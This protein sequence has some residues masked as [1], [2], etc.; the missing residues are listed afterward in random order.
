[1]QN[2]NSLEVLSNSL[3]NRNMEGIYFGSTGVFFENK[4]EKV[5]L[6]VNRTCNFRCPYCYAETTNYKDEMS[7]DL[8][9]Q[10]ILFSKRMGAKAVILIGGE[11]L[12]YS[13]LDEIISYIND[14]EM[15][16]VV[17]TNGLEITKKRIQNLIND[18]KIYSIGFSLKG[19]D[20]KSY[21]EQT[22]VDSFERIK[23]AIS[24]FSNS[25]VQGTYSFVLTKQTHDKLEKVAQLVSYDNKRKLKFIL[26][27]PVVW[28]D[29]KISGEQMLPL[30][31][32]I[33]SFQKQYDEVNKVLDGRLV[34][35]QSLP[36]CVW[37]SD[38]IARL[39]SLNQIQFGC[40]I[41]SQKGLVFGIHGE[42]LICNSITDFPVAYF[43][44]DFCDRQSFISFINN[45]DK[46]DLFHKIL[47]YPLTQCGICDKKDACFGGCPFKWFV[48]S[49]QECRNVI[50]SKCE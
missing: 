36:T 15:K 25:S 18:N 31:E 24:I 1:M 5:W 43:G 7:L 12:L 49:A 34:L 41:R 4:L 23:E 32:L 46:K 19:W 17:V 47:K 13:K 39:K 44:R 38:F 16:V 35:Q 22:K 29:G 20:A 33:V 42:V 10:L 48:Y 30:S 3:L 9:K 11:P 28:G 45:E 27:N 2:L 21:L 26:C 50:Q 6:T 37:P 40:N 8:A 14:N